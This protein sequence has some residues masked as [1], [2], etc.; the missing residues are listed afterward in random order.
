M[1]KVE[2]N[3]KNILC[4]HLNSYICVHKYRENA[5]NVI[6]YNHNSCYLHCTAQR[7]SAIQKERKI[8]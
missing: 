5:Y 8:R 2:L 3:D 1:K 6:V 7:K 4:N